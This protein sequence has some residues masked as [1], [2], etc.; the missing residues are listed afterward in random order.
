MP[1]DGYEYKT[2]GASMIDPATR[3][4]CPCPL[5]RIA[6]GRAGGVS[7]LP[8]GDRRFCRRQGADAPRS[9]RLDG[10]VDHEG[11]A[12]HRQ[13]NKHVE[14]IRRTA[15]AR[16]RVDE[17]RIL[18]GPNGRAAIDRAS[19]LVRQ[20]RAREDWPPVSPARS[21]GCSRR[22]RYDHIGLDQDN[23]GTRGDGLSPVA[24]GFKDAIDR[25]RSYAEVYSDCSGVVVTPA[26]IGLRST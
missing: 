14:G 3:C 8:G 16:S 21:P 23:L 13:R 4:R 26:R 2:A 22:P 25:I 10:R 5:D 1:A 9:P 18:Q 19:P 24:G 7:P 11:A 15:R 12:R 17:G 6:A 20:G